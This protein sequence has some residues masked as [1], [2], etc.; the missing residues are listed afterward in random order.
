LRE[1][2]GGVSES[3]RRLRELRDIDGFAFLTHGAR[4]NLN[5]RG[6]RPWGHTPSA[7][8]GATDIEGVAVA[9]PCA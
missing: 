4:E 8:S 5:G 6:I 1:G 7:S 3:T 2:A 9:R